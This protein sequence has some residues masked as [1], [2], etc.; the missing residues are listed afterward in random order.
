MKEIC[1]G[2]GNVN[3]LKCADDAVLLVENENGL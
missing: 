3:N 1:I 2:R